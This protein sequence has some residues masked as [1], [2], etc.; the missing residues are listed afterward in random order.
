M[1][2]LVCV[3]SATREGLHQIRYR[4]KTKPALR[5]SA[6]AVNLQDHVAA[7]VEWFP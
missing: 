2:V 6:S 5:E 1:Q 7:F 3:G 4:L